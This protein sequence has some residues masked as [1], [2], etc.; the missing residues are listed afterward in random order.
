[1]VVEWKSDGGERQSREKRAMEEKERERER[2]R[3]S[4]RKKKKKK[5]GI[6]NDILIKILALIC[7]FFLLLDPMV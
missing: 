7:V 4:E 1:M 3:E 5:Q 2:E 6:I